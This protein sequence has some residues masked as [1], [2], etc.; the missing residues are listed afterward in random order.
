M[1]TIVENIALCNALNTVMYTTIQ[2][3]LRSGAIPAN[4]LVGTAKH[5]IRVIHIRIPASTYGLAFPYFVCVRSTIVPIIKSVTASIA[6]L[7]AT[8]VEIAA[9]VNARLF[10]A[11]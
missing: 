5:A 1:F 9:A 7:I 8:P 10:V 2:R 4:Q 11:K 3:F 6:V